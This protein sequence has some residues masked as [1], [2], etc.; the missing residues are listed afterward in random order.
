MAHAAHKGLLVQI[1]DLVAEMRTDLSERWARHSTY[2]ETLN[3]LQDL[4]PREMADLGI[5]PSML[6]SIA[7]E[8]AYK[9]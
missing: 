3:E 2:R 9:N 4:S 5:N 7:Y 1:F 6:R 8:A